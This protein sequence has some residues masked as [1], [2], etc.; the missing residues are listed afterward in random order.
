MQLDQLK[1]SGQGHSVRNTRAGKKRKKGKRAWGLLGLG[2]LGQKICEGAR[3]SVVG[4]GVGR[5]VYK[6]REITNKSWAS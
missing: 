5:L 1:T 2:W 6:Y 3:A 4:E